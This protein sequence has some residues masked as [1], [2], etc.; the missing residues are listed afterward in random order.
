MKN[1]LNIKVFYL[2]NQLFIIIQ[3]LFS[4]QI[5]KYDLFKDKKRS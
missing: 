3:R 1:Y 2:K 4:N 5:A